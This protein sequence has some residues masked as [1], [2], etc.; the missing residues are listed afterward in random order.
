[1]RKL[2]VILTMLTALGT[3]GAGAQHYDRGYETLP[4][5]PFV[6]KG[7]WMLGGTARYSQHINKDYSFLVI[8]DINSTGYTVAVTPK[9]LYMFHDNMG[10][11]ISFS[12][13]RGMLDLN[14]ANLSVSEITM[15]AKDCYEV[16]QSYTAH[17]VYR[18]YIPFGN[19]K[20]LAMYADL[21]LGGSYSQGKVYNAGGASTIGTYEQ[22]F[23]AE[24]AVDPGLTAFLTDRLAIEMNVGIFGVSYKWSDQI[25]NQAHHG[26]YDTTQAGFMLNLLSFGFGISYYL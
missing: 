1:M 19:S 22:S 24:L 11:G 6:T 14:E 21:K 5:S 8:N 20:R 23:K 13:N 18:A 3:F 17:G 25:H 4:S 12:Y 2:I 26:S 16:H 9:L 15:S 10:A 7:T